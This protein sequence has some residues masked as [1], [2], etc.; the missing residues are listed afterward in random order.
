MQPRVGAATLVLLVTRQRTHSVGQ[1][2]IDG[3]DIR[4]QATG[5]AGLPRI[6]GASLA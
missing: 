3:G 2:S 1:H 4:E 6:M 5:G